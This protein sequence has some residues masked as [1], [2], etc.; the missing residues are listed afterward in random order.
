MFWT[1]AWAN[2]EIYDIGKFQKLPASPKIQ[3]SKIS[4][5]HHFHGGYKWATVEHV[6]SEVYKIHRL[7]LLGFIDLFEFKKKFS[8][9]S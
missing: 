8:S 5:K 1:C 2:I 7:Y 3:T 9:L 6:F 4:E